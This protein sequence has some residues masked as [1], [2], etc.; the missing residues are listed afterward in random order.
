MMQRRVAIVLGRPPDLPLEQEIHLQQIAIRHALEPVE[1][2]YVRA[3]EPHGRQLGEHLFCLG[4]A[5]VV[6]DQRNLDEDVVGLAQDLLAAF[7]DIKFR[8]LGVDLDEVEPPAT[9]DVV[10]SDLVDL[11][12]EHHLVAVERRVLAIERAAGRLQPL[13][14]EEQLRP[15]WLR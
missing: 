2:S 14:G 13:L 10:D 6:F 15:P 1:V 9:E 4:A 12:S 8:A 5:N 3:A 7:E 11:L